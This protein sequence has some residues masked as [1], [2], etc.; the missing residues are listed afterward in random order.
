MNSLLFLCVTVLC[1]SLSPVPVHS[2]ST[3]GSVRLDSI[4]FD[5]LLSKFKISLVKFDTPFPYG[6]KHEQFELVA[7]SVASTPDLLVAEVGIAD[8]GE[9]ENMELAEKFDLKKDN[10]P[11]LLL[12]KGTN[13]ISTFTGEWNEQSMKGF[14]KEKGGLR[15]QLEGCLSSLDEVAQEFT[16]SD[17][18]ESRE[19][20]LKKAEGIVQSLENKSEKESG[21]IYTK[22]MQRVIERGEKFLESEGERVKNLLT[23]KISDAKKKVLQLRLNII[24]SFQRV[25]EEIP[26]YAK[27][28]L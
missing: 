15:L 7:K 1:L 9:K 27:Q 25:D 3:Q 17:E 14:L 16:G 18:K 6:D 22:L 28:D 13:M 12:F 26:A 2:L 10:Y 11:Y 21:E 8:Y 19:G 23:G 24:S 4:T 5:K 20:L